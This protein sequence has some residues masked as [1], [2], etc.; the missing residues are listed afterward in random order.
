MVAAQLVSDEIPALKPEETGLKAIGWME[1]FKIAELP[2][3]NGPK[4]LGLISETDILDGNLIDNAVQSIESKFS[5]VCVGQNEHIFEVIRIM[6]E[7][8]LS[9]L[10]VLDEQQRYLG[11][12]IKGDLV[13]RI[14]LTQS[15]HSPGGIIQLEM[16]IHDYS[17]AEIARLIES[18]D[19]KILNLYIS[20]H[21]DS[22]KMEVTIKINKS[23]LSRIIQTF[24]RFDYSITGS[25]H[26]SHFEDDL[27][28]RYESFMRYLNM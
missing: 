7:N 3:T 10:P 24:N 1:E 8:D 16:N 27:K 6:A 2:V 26:Q 25:F 11:V 4:Y 13:K 18:N 17:L 23:D 28:N 22:K 20:T 12:I 9:I 21:P 5:P 14:A 15:L 19:A